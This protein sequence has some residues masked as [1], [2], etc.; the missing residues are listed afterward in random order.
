MSFTG[1]GRVRQSAARVTL[2]TH[3]WRASGHTRAAGPCVGL[4]LVLGTPAL[5][6]LGARARVGLQV[7]LGKHML[8]RAN[9]CGHVGAKQ[10]LLHAL[11]RA[12]CG[13]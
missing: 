7:D 1:R 2:R 11:Q 13:R 3:L 8:G 12:E 5:L 10:P 4:F 9:G 6:R